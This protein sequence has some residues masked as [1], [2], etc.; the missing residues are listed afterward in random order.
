[1]RRDG[2]R[3]LN[4]PLQLFIPQ[5]APS[6]GDFLFFFI[7]SKLTPR[8]LLDFPFS[9]THLPCPPT[10]RELLHMCTRQDIPKDAQGPLVVDHDLEPLNGLLETIIRLATREPP[11]KSESSRAR[12]AGR[13][14]RLLN[15]SA[16]AFPARVVPPA[17]TSFGGCR[18]SP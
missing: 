3:A 14:T 18:R 11:P 9:P 1:M 15:Q 4:T 7:A 12:Y 16:S 5:D 8:L 6:A 2:S 10:A 17:R 13:L